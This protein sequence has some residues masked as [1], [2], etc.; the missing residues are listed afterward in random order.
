MDSK[1]SM[2]KVDHTQ[3]SLTCPDCGRS[4][5][6]LKQYAFVDYV[7]FLVLA[8][9]WQRTVHVACPACMRWF[10]ARKSLINIV[11]ANILWLVFLLPWTLILF[12][13][14][15]TKGHS[16]AVRERIDQALR[17]A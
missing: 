4:T 13:R 9:A 11:P 1:I 8:A 12:A 14:S 17:S 3:I 7:V 10:V 15:Y 2:Q 6:S 16:K 5:Y